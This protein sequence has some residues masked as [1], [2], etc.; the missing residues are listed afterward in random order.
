[1]PRQLYPVL[2]DEPGDCVGCGHEPTPGNPV[3]RDV[4]T[5]DGVMH[6]RLCRSCIDQAPAPDQA[7]AIATLYHD[8]DGFVWVREV[9]GDLAGPWLSEAAARAEYAA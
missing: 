6:K 5:P 1:M 8:L 3:Y 9:N 4:E 7:P 2:I